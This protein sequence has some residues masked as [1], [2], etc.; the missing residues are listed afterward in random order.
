MEMIILI[1]I[2]ENETGCND[3]DDDDDDDND[4]WELIWVLVIG[5]MASCFLLNTRGKNLR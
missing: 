1:I 2:N 4:N 5:M 3:Y